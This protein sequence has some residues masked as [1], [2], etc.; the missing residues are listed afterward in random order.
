MSDTPEAKTEEVLIKTV[1]DKI[2]SDLIGTGIFLE[3]DVYQ[4][5]QDWTDGRK[6]TTHREYPYSYGTHPAITNG[7]VDVLVETSIENVSLILIL[8]IECKKADPALKHWVFEAQRSSRPKDMPM[9]LMC[10][11]GQRSFTQEYSLSN[12]GYGT[13]KDYENS[14]NVFEF[15]EA[16]GQV[17][18]NAN[19]ELRAYYAIKQ[20]NESIPGLLERL[21]KISR[22]IDAPHLIIPIVVTTANLFVADYDPA[23]IKRAAG[24]IEPDKLKLKPKDWVLYSYPLEFHESVM[25]EGDTEQK[26][27]RPE[28][29]STFVVNSS[30]LPNFIKYL[31]ADMDYLV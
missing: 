25:A 13:Y 17:S 22:K 4:L 20:V 15:S 27:L 10:S 18:R 7:T 11:E 29:R 9:L 12:L 16:K 30:A 28:K 26:G 3:R 8:P 21:D 23:D 5:F 6:F 24:D 31:I 14:V 2:K 1:S 19:R